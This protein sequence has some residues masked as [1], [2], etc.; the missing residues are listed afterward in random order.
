MK[1]MTLADRTGMVETE[2]FAETNRIHGLPIRYPVLE[3]IATVEPF[4][5]GHGFSLRVHQAGKQ[6]P[7]VKP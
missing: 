2:L 1:F 4:E 3:V 6:R 7:V 5:N